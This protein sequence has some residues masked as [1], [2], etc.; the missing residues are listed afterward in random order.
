MIANNS[1]HVFFFVLDL[2]MTYYN[3]LIL[4]YNA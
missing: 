3:N 2:E 1:T 4:D